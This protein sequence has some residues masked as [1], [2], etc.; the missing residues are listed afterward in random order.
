MSALQNPAQ[1]L[2]PSCLN[3]KANAY[4]SMPYDNT[5]TSLPG[6]LYLIA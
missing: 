4:I 3:V 2:I 6:T 5:H 1:A